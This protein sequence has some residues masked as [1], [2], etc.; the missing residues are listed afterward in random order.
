VPF[1]DTRH[2]R[3]SATRYA[4]LVIATTDLLVSTQNIESHIGSGKGRCEKYSLSKSVTIQA[5]C[6][7]SKLANRSQ[8]KDNPT[9]QKLRDSIPA[10]PQPEKTVSRRASTLGGADEVSFAAVVSEDG[11]Y[12]NAR[13]N[14]HVE[15][16]QAQSYALRRRP[17]PAGA[18]G[19]VLSSFPAPHPQS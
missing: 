2:L 19:P 11:R 7:G 4:C 3:S 14:P 5:I 15:M 10:W 18:C 12:P 6:P 13:I 17:M 9:S 16:I 1:Q 8:S